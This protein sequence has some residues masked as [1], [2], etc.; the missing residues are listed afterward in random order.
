MGV[1]SFAP[2]RKIYFKR[3]KQNKLNYLARGNESHNRTLPRP[4]DH[5]HIQTNQRM[6]FDIPVSFSGNAVS[7]Q[8]CGDPMQA[9][10]GAAPRETRWAEELVQAW[11]THG[12]CRISHPGEQTSVG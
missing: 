12:C 8:M 6:R 9:A 5:A 3:M 4:S 2:G 1:N 10:R 11:E 7:T